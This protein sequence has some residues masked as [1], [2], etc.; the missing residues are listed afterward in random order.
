MEDLRLESLPFDSKAAGYD[1]YG[2][3]VYDRA[4]G[5]AMLRQTFAQFFTNG[6]FGTPAETFLITKGNGLSV[7]VAEGVAIINGAI[8]SVPEGGV[9]VK[10][11]DE[12]TTVGSYAYGIYLR[13]DENSDKRSCY[14]VVRKG[15]AGPNP[16]PPGPDRSTPG[17]WELRLGYVVVPSGA[18]DLGGAT[19]TNEKG[20]EFC[21]FAAPFAEIDVSEILNEVKT[22]S[23][24]EYNDF[25]EQLDKY[26]ELL[27]SALD[28]STAGNLQNQIDELR[29]QVEGFDLSG[30]VDNETI[31]FAES[32]LGGEKKLSVK[33]G[34]VTTD[35]I[36][37]G[38]VTTDK[39]SKDAIG[40]LTEP[41]PGKALSAYTWEEL[42]IL[43]SNEK[44]SVEDLKYFIGQ[45]KTV[46]M[47]GI[48][49]EDFICIGI[50]HDNAESGGKAGITLMSGNVITKKAM[51]SSGSASGGWESC[52]VRTW[53]N[54]DFLES[55]PK[56]LQSAIKKVKKK[57]L[58]SPGAGVSESVD[59]IFLISL[60]EVSGV[61]TYGDDGDVYEYWSD[62]KPSERIMHK[63]G[64]KP[65]EDEAINKENWWLRSIVAE[66]QFISIQT[67][68]SEY[69][70]N[71]NTSYGMV[72]CFCL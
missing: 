38:A 43:F 68:G 31:E 26:L 41:K 8:S 39:L 25:V 56:D 28:E 1:D 64:Y 52:E 71:A 12:T 72:P 49:E 42:G 34:G 19:V 36:A 48:G 21:P 22:A 30:S 58:K 23:V 14:I 4:V 51:N 6:V 17:I 9:S 66:T 35:K 32:E 59:S 24:E 62:K 45:T 7:N 65:W 40:S 10:L 46:S 37:D 70:V 29:A 63:M 53:L 16:T 5:A 54:G 20:L 13:Y 3:P 33:D 47:S 15:E 50:R 67:S 69:G 57:Y 55:L 18:T 44:Y 60:P 11:T 2:Y 61:K 27:K